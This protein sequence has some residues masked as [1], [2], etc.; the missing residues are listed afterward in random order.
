M[1]QSIAVKPAV[2]MAAAHFVSQPSGRGCSQP[3]FTRAR[4]AKPPGCRSP[5]PQPVSTTACPGVKSGDSLL[6]TVPAKSMPA[7][8]GGLLM[9]GA[10]PVSAS[11]SL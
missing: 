8:I 2:P 7:V 3:A 10:R 1:T 4:W 5:T 11:P 6:S 9:I